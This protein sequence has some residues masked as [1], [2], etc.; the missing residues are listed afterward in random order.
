[1]WLQHVVLRW[2]KYTRG[3][4]YSSLRN[5]YQRAFKLPATALEFH[6]D[7]G[8]PCHTISIWQDQEGFRQKESLTI[9][10][11]GAEEWNIGC[12]DVL[13]EDE[14]LHVDFRYEAFLGAPYRYDYWGNLLHERAFSLKSDEYGRIQ[15]NG[16]ISTHEDPYYE[17]NIMNIYNGEKVDKHCFSSHDPDQEYRQ[18]VDLY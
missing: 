9:L 15:Y 18:I 8:M 1:M 4:P 3:A 14:W 2:D 12:I 7:Y 6:R 11:P 5:R 17:L 16:R 13:R 10:K